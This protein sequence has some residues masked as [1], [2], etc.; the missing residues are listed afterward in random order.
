[1]NAQRT[2]MAVL[3]LLISISTSNASEQDAW[4][5]LDRAQQLLSQGEHTEAQAALRRAAKE[6]PKNAEIRLELGRSYLHTKNA[7]GAARELG[8]ALKLGSSP[9]LVTMPLTLA[10]LRSGERQAVVDLLAKQTNLSLR[11]LLI[12]ANSELATGSTEAALRDFTAAHETAPRLLSALLGLA[13]TMAALD[14]DADTERWLQKAISAAPESPKPWR[15]LGD[16]D[17]KRRHPWAALDRYLAALRLDPHS[18]ILRIQATDLLIKTGNL[19]AANPLLQSLLRDAPTD[20]R[21]QLLEAAIHLDDNPQRARHIIDGVVKLHPGNSKAMLYLAEVLMRQREYDRALRL[22]HRYRLVRPKD[23]AGPR[24]LGL[25]HARGGSAR[26]GQRLLEE[27]L[28][29]FPRDTEV[30]TGLKIAASRNGDFQ[31]AADYDVQ[32]AS[33]S[34]AR[35]QFDQAL[36]QATQA[37]RDAALQQLKQA[38]EPAGKFYLEEL[39]KYHKF[40]QAQ[41]FPDATRTLRKLVDELPGNARIQLL[42]GGSLVAQKYY[43]AA[44]IAMEA[45]WNDAPGTPDIGLQLAS[46]LV[47]QDQ[48]VQAIETYQQILQAH[49]GHTEAQARLSELTVGLNDDT[50]M[51]YLRQMVE[52]NPGELPARI[53][54]SKA[55]AAQGDVRQGLEVLTEVQQDYRKHPDYLRQALELQ[56]ASGDWPAA[57]ASARQLLTLEPETAKAHL[58]LA[59]L[60]GQTGDIDAMSAEIGHAVSLEGPTGLTFQQ[61]VELAELGGDLASARVLLE[62]LRKQQPADPELATALMAIAVREKRHKEVFLLLD[63]MKQ[64][65]PKQSQWTAYEIRLLRQTGQRAAA[66]KKLKQALLTYPDSPQLRKLSDRKQ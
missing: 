36:Q 49:P 17:L 60:Y 43:L 38:G 42:L 39:R 35:T 57:T 63:E 8:K 24:L 44:Q 15:L 1:M 23:P 28:Q 52:A 9:R 45:A 20:V 6:A 11:L 14:Q 53:L 41:Q 61:L 33:I 2:T 7:V 16:L 27:Q 64:R 47:S 32:I 66:S 25:I 59:R 22:I 50:R 30:L 13:K 29:L 37:E 18:T 5:H 34:Q 21:V 55:L 62:N 40:F 31:V 46:L 56:Q 48:P 65:Y 3:L 54:L 51:S 26:D 12:R 19:D 4:K 58:R 10:L